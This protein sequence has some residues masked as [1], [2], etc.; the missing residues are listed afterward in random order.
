MSFHCISSLIL[1]I[2]KTAIGETKSKHTKQ[3]KFLALTELTLNLQRQRLTIY[4]VHGM[5]NVVEK[6]NTMKGVRS[7]RGRREG[8]S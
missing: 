3:G 1:H 6:C 7:I 5:V 8:V 2:G 4:K